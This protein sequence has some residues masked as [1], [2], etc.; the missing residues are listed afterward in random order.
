[1]SIGWRNNLQRW[2]GGILLLGSWLGLAGCQAPVQPTGPTQ[3]VLHVNDYE[4]FL[5][6]ALTLLRQYDFPPQYV[7]RTHGL[8]V[9]QPTTSG[10]WFEWW[11]VDSRGGYQVL[12]SSL[13]TIQRVVTLR[14]E[15]ADTTGGATTLPSATDSAAGVVLV[16][17]EAAAAPPED[18]LSA[19]VAPICGRFRLTVQVDKS[20]LT[21]PDRQVTTASGALGMYSVRVPTTEGERLRVRDSH[22]VPLGR[23][24]LL[25]EYL[26]QELTRQQAVETRT[27]PTA[28]DEHG[29]APE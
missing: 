29:T 16:A 22:W 23:D 8:V 17:D 15:P 11:R 25:E 19:P 12:E 4:T 5:D 7:D 2:M 21:Q 13:H 1:M 28:V 9:S 27:E 6:D 3:V 26:L 10:Q 14:V 24:G 18:A 20:R